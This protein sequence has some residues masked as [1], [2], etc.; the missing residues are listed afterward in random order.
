VSQAP[1][2]H[3]RDPS[4][5]RILR[6]CLNAPA[7][8]S[9][10]NEPRARQPRRRAPLITSPFDLTFFVLLDREDGPS[11]WTIMR[12]GEARMVAR[13][14]GLKFDCPVY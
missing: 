13:H 1:A 5:G 12:A 9:E 7:H 4:I 6:S 3:F 14:F 2:G 11:T 10:W 8:S